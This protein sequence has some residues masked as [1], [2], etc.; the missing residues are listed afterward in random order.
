MLF[1]EFQGPAGK[2]KLRVTDYDL[3]LVL[4]QRNLKKQKDRC[5]NCIGLLYN[6]ILSGPDYPPKSS[7]L[8]FS[9]GTPKSSHIF[10][11]ALFING[12]PQ[13]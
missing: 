12:G 6:N 7:N 9:G 1:F 4:M 3:L 13:K 5:S 8:T 10:S 11:T 2:A